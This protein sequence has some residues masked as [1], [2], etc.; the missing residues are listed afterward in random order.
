MQRLTRQLNVLYPSLP[1]N[2]FFFTFERSALSIS[3]GETKNA[4]IIRNCGDKLVWHYFDRYD[5]N[6]PV[7]MIMICEAFLSLNLKIKQR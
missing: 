5:E 7:I 3:T 6:S 2:N 1:E 4:L